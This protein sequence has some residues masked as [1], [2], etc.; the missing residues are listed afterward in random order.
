MSPLNF[1]IYKEEAIHFRA[2]SS[3]FYFQNT[4]AIEQFSAGQLGPHA[5]IATLAF[6]FLVAIGYI[7]IAFPHSYGLLGHAVMAFARKKKASLSEPL[8]Y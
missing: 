4:F 7:S 1:Y 6:F 8:I 2:L 5:S 3:L